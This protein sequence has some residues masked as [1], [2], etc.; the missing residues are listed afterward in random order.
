MWMI[1]NLAPSAVTDLMLQD[2]NSTALV[3]SY[4]TPSSPNGI[5]ISYNIHYVPVLNGLS[6]DAEEITI[7]ISPD[8]ARD[9]TEI[10]SGLVAFTMYR[11]RVAA[12]T[13]IGQGEV[14][15][16]VAST[17]PT[18]SSPPN[19]FTAVA[20]TS[21]SITLTWSYPQTPRGI[22]Q[23][24]IIRYHPTHD[25]D[26]TRE[27]NI[28]LLTENDNRMQFSTIVNLI[29]FTSYMFVVRAFSF[30]SDP[31]VVHQGVESDPLVIL[32]AETGI[33]L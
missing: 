31:F 6:T 29:P 18:S 25:L 30:G 14:E 4:S 33:P 8:D 26:D 2:V 1:I 21:D 12:V 10:I 27:E 19:N 16:R 24:Y 15:E 13:S 32:T 3:V 23:G 28:T 11:V 20:I 5:I 9:H 7:V 22:I 17:D